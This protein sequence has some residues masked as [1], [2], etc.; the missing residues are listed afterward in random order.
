MEAITLKPW[1]FSALMDDGSFV[2][3][4]IKEYS[5]SSEH[6]PYGDLP[7]YGIVDPAGGQKYTKL[8]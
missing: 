7:Q 8:K 6:E 1:R 4:V 2:S 5:F 3:N